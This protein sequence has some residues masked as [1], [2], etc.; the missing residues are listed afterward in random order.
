MSFLMYLLNT[1]EIQINLGPDAAGKTFTLV[2]D[3][4]PPTRVQPQ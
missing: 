2:V 3:G 4:L 1:G